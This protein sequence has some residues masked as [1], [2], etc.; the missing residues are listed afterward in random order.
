MNLKKYR[1]KINEMMSR[2]VAQVEGSIAMDMLDINRVS[3]DVLIPLFSE[4]YGHTGLKNLNVS[5]GSNFPAID[6]GDEKARTA[7]QITSTSDS[8]KIKDTLRKFVAHRLYERYDRLIIY[9]LTMKQDAYRVRFDE[10]I[11]EEFSFDKDKDILDYRDLLREISGFPLEKTRR[12]ANILEQH[13]VERREDDKPQNILDWLEYVNNLWGE[14]SGT[15]KINR[16]KLRDDLSSFALRGNGVV[17]GSPGVGKT[18]LIKELRRSLESAEIPE[19]LLPIDQLGDGTDKTLRKELS[20]E[21]DLIERLKSVPVSGK[22]ALLLFDAFDAARDEQ[23]RKRFLDLIRRAI[24]ELRESWNIVVTVRTYDAKKSQELLDLFGNPDE[25]DLTQYKSKD[26]LCRHFTIPSFDED[27]ILQAFDRIGCPRSIYG[28]GSQDFKNILAN[29]FNLW[30]LEKI[31]KSSQDLPDFSQV[32]SEVQLLGLF[33]Q[34]RIDN[35]SS[36]YVLRRIARRMVKERSLTVKADD[37]Y[38][39]ID[40]DKSARKTAWD[41]LQSDEILSKVSS[42]GQRVAFSHNILFDYAISVLLI[43]DQPQHLEN[44]ISEDPS[45][46]LFLRPSLTYFFTRL[47]YYDSTSF[48]NAFWHILPSNQSVHLRL[49]ARLIPTAVIV[50]EAREIEQLTPLLEKLRNREEIANEAITRLLQSLRTLQ[51]E[52]DNIWSKIYDWISTNLHVNFASDLAILT[53]DILDRAIETEN[54]NLIDTCG[55]IGRR[56]LKW[57]WQERETSENDWYNRLGGFWAVPLVAK[58]YSTNVKRSRELLEKVLQLTKEENFPIGFLTWLTDHVDRIWD[59]DPEFVTSIY[60]TVF[61]HDETSDAKTNLG[62]S[63]VLSMTSFR[64]QDYRMCQYRL[65]KHFPNFLRAAPLNATQAAIRSLN[66]F[67]IREHIVRYLKEGVTLEDMIETF[68]FRE[69]SAYF[70]EDGSY[71]WDAQNS[72]DE[73]IKLANALFEFIEKLAMSEDSRFDLILDVFRD[74]VV[75]AFFWKRL[76]KIGA[77]FPKIFATRLFELCIARPIQMHSETFYELGVFLEAAMYEFTSDQLCRI[78]ESILA[79]PS[80]ATDENH[81]NFLEEERNRL[82]ARVPTN[83]LRT[84][85][86]MKIREEMDRKNSVPVN[87]PPVSFSTWSEPVTQEKWLQGRGVDT[88]TPENQELQRFSGNLNKFSSDWLNESPTQEAV[89]LILP[90]LKEV[91]VTLKSNTEADKEV[92][93]LLWRNLTGC[94]AILGRIANNLEIDSFTFCRQMLLEGAKHEGPKPNPIHD[95]QFDSPGYSPFP[96]HEAARGLLRFAF[97][98]PDSEI[99]DAIETLAG[100]PSAIRPDGN[101]DGLV[102]GLRQRATKILADHEQ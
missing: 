14:E 98:Q 8:G 64:S 37:L 18:Y 61:F 16:E 24:L 71:I 80:E 30:L 6:L 50:T 99:L 65:V 97:H 10:I 53:S 51:I 101:S 45:R 89:E 84:D 49:F 36:E 19:L 13:F 12:V 100:D 34:R 87:R 96:R 11:P 46:P 28:D 92:I 78:E 90:R 81:L 9:I 33:W 54:L 63:H 7:Y 86:A 68:N 58:T 44:F 1:D 39:D 79:L 57:V 59:H 69:K 4:V 62:N 82:L 75:V 38:D 26:I 42:T 85:K 48:W 43:D 66:V 25:A 55:Q 32:R 56:L 17:I 22:R 20:Y 93:N 47:W 35:E 94:V 72:S 29:P 5:E 41:K 3:E 31:L 102:Y 95:E 73:P 83:L 23:T 52:R 40:L 76:L 91:Y 60:R 88:T 15:I 2:F 21:G 70:M 74:E 27:E 67:I 77:Q